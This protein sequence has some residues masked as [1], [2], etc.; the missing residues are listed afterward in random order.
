MAVISAPYKRHS[1]YRI[2]LGILNVALFDVILRLTPTRY[3]LGYLNTKLG[4]FTSRKPLA[5]ILRRHHS[6]SVFSKV[7]PLYHGA[8]V[9]LG[10]VFLLLLGD[11]TTAIMGARNFLF[12]AITSRRRR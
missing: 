7:K 10:N 8:I 9:R 5:I 12:R 11:I 3:F 1:G 2:Q 4:R 6:F